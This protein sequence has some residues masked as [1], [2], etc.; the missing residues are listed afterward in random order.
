METLPRS[1]RIP[2]DLWAQAVAKARAED[3]TLTAKVVEFLR[4]YVTRP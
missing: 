2:T 1:L 3:T 4:A